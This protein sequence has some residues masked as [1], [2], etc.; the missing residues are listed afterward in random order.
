MAKKEQ[1]YRVHAYIHVKSIPENENGETY[2][3]RIMPQLIPVDEYFDNEKYG[4]V[5]RDDWI[6][7]KEAEALSGFYGTEVKVS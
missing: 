2:I 5:S 3:D 7:K 6:R 1:K 4:N